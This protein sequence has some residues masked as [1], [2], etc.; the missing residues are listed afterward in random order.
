MGEEKR[1]K[2]GRGSYFGY[3]G[4]TISIWSHK[5]WT[6]WASAK[7]Q[8]RD[9]KFTS[10]TF[11]YPPRSHPSVR[12]LCAGFSPSVLSLIGDDLVANGDR[13]MIDVAV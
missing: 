9:F 10:G 11:T 5:V 2:G 13:M 8:I 3:T 4:I 12:H 6:A 1:R 7:S